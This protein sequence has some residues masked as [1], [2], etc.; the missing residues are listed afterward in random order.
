M[1]TN[2]FGLPKSLATTL[3]FCLVL[4]ILLENAVAFGDDWPTFRGPSRTSVSNGTKLTRTWP[5][6]GPKLL[7][8]TEGAGRSYASV[9]IVNDRIYTLGDSLSTAE[10]K[11]EYLSCFDKKS[12]K[13]IWKS[14]T[15]TPWNEGQPSWQ[16]S[17]STP[18]VADGKVYVITPT[19]SLVCC[20]AADGKLLWSKDLTDDEFGGSKDDIWGYSESPLIDGPHVVCTPGGAKTTMVKL[21]R[22]NGEVVWKTARP[23]DR[24]AGHASI[25]IAKVGGKTVYVQTTGSGALGVDAASGQ[26]LWEYPFDKTTAVIPTPIVR[27]DLVFVAAGYG[28]GGALLRQVPG[29]NGAITI[30]EVYG[31]N[32]ALANKHGGIVLVG[33]YLYGD[34]DDKGMPFCADFMTG[35]IKWKSRGAGKNSAVVVSGD[36]LIFVQFADGV[37]AMAEANA[38]EYK[39]IANFTIPTSG[40]RPSWAH[41]VILEGKLYVR[42]Q[43]K[44]FCYDISAK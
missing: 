13:Q 42:E 3:S 1:M 43:D 29:A 28:R 8:Q 2:G 25:V 6:A 32:K 7:W 24:G 11:D 14:K 9:A 34:S 21:N 19:G 27:D 18:T 30:Q 26:M 33:D 15:G 4:S 37:L 16:S 44:I 31:L 20:N 10:D 35:E 38:N 17:R 22:D 23:G 5:A 36:G 12:G 41:P 40:N 39:E